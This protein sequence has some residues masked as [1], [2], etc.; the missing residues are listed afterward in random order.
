MPKIAYIVTCDIKE[1][2]QNINWVVPE[3]AGGPN[4][5]NMSKKGA[6]RPLERLNINWEEKY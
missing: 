2:S 6:R 5:A 4:Y 3:G 1:P